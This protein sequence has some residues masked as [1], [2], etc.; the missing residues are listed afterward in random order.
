MKKLLLFIALV[1]VT[2]NS[3]SQYLIDGLNW[4]NTTGGTDDWG[5]ILNRNYTFKV[6]GDTT[7]GGVV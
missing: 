2:T 3:Y 6:E 4:N 7:I 1:F 5:V